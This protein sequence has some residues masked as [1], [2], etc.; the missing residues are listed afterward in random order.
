MTGSLYL[1]A[2]LAGSQ[3]A[4]AVGDHL[5]AREYRKVFEKGVTK[6]D[7]LTWNGEYYIQAYDRA[8]DDKYQYG[9]GCVSDQVLG[10]WLALVSGLDRFLPKD[11]VRSALDSI[12]K[13][14]FRDGFHK[15]YHGMRT[16]ALG[17][18]QGLVNCSWPGGDGSVVPFVYANEVWTGTEYQVAS[19]FIYEGRVKE[20]LTIVKAIRERHDG[21]KRNP[22]NEE[23]SRNHYA[24]AMSS[25]GVF[26]A[27][28]GF[29]YSGTE[30]KMGFD[31]RIHQEDFRCFWSCGSGWGSFSQK[32]EKGKRNKIELS[33]THGNLKLVEFIFRLPPSLRGENIASLE[34]LFGDNS[35]KIDFIQE[36]DVI[37]VRW[38][39]P[40][41]ISAGENLKLKIQF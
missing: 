26:L 19:H 21:W 23:E 33:V 20:G 27:L 7:E 8:Y 12:F 4:D 39:K 14:N 29:E 2:L 38:R 24:R 32:S 22:W 15:D 6:L 11:H 31:P 10:Q 36:G 1:G 25:W 18:E 34:G 37:H 40:F 30:M 9:T 5:S 41:V 35:V 13:Y 17:N 28:T 3:M 16:F